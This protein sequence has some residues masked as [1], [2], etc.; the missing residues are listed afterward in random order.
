MPDL[1]NNTALLQLLRL[2]SPAL[3]VGSYSYSQGLEYAC[4]AG[5]IDDAGSAQSWF[6]GVMSNGLARLDVPIL[7]RIY[8]ACEEEAYDNAI[9]W[10]RYVLACRET[11][12]LREEDKQTGRALGRLL[13][14]LEIKQ[15]DLCTQSG[16]AS[17]VF[18]FA[19]AAQSWSIPLQQTA[20]GYL[21]AWLENQVAAAIKLI[22]LGQTQGQKILSESMPFIESCVNTGL[23]IEDGEIYGSLPG[24]ALGSALH[25]TQ[26]SRLF[27]S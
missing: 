23:E 21:W 20:C 6:N 11:L 4:E 5:W 12:E 15:A 25:E 17:L 8:H 1:I 7:A 27:Q 16:H 9:S 18:S 14:D 22:P 10:S 24:L 13:K 26:Y 2:T 3:P 19:L